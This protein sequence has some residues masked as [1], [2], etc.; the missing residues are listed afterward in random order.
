MFMRASWNEPWR[1]ASGPCLNVFK[2]ERWT[3]AN[4][5]AC[6]PSVRLYR[7]GGGRDMVVCDWLKLCH[8]ESW[9]SCEGSS[10]R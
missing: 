6:Q 2:Y 1:N 10:W 9:I 7:W 4:G 3:S 5:S 8:P